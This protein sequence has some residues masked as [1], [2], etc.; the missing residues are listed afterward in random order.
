MPLVALH[1][2]A[3]DHGDIAVAI[4]EVIPKSGY[5]R[6]Y[7]DLPGMGHSTSTG[8]TS[9]DDVVELLIEFIEHVVGSQSCSSVIRTAHI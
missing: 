6:I 5:R 9:N 8:L 3:V 1:G 4:E 7:P 2:A